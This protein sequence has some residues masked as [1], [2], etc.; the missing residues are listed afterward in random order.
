MQSAGDVRMIRDWTQNGLGLKLLVAAM[1]LLLVAGLVL[2]LFGLM[3]GAGRLG[4]T[5]GEAPAAFPDLRLALPPGARV[6]E[7]T[8]AGDRLYLRAEDSQGR[9]LVLVVDV[10]DGRLIGRILLESGR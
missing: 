4:G 6:V 10:R 2:L 7:S 1:T 8:A 5:A 9:G 3:R